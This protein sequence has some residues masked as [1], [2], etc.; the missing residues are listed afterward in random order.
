MI[1][2]RKTSN[3]WIKTVC[4]S[5]QLYKDKDTRIAQKKRFSHNTNNSPA[6]VNYKT[7]AKIHL[8]Q[9]GVFYVSNSETSA[10]AQKTKENVFTALYL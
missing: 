5:D 9:M 2:T 6:Y 10:T 8:E 1:L 3:G 4:Q 7:E